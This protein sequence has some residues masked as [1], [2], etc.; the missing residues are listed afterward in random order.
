MIAC[1]QPDQ[2]PFILRIKRHLV[3]HILPDGLPGN[4]FIHPGQH[5]CCCSTSRTCQQ[6]DTSLRRRLFDRPQSRSQHNHIPNI[7]HA[8]HQNIPGRQPLIHPVTSRPVATCFIA[9]ASAPPAGQAPGPRPSSTPPLAPT[10]SLPVA[11]G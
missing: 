9:S 5:P 3:P 6:R 10:S 1:Q 11:T 2:L 7:I 4:H 8:H